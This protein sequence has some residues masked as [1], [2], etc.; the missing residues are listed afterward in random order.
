MAGGVKP[1]NI[2]YMTFTRNTILGN[3]PYPKMLFTNEGETTDGDWMQ[4]GC[5]DHI[6]YK[7]EEITPK[8][9]LAVMKGDKEKAKEL[10]GREDPRVLETTSEDTIFTYII[11]DGD[12]GKVLIGS[13]QLFVD[14]LTD[15]F[16]YAHENHR[17]KSWVWFVESC[18]SSTLFTGL[19]SDL[20]IYAMASSDEKNEPRMGCCPPHDVVAGKGL[21]TCLGSYWENIL[22]EYMEK[23]PS[24]KIGELFSYSHDEVAKG[25][26]QNVSEFGDMTMKELPISDFVGEWKVIS[27]SL[28]SMFY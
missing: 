21:Y 10:T 25:S 7:E 16:Q 13:N 26:D 5:H 27:P 19:P 23:T 24:A 4:H 6:D 17:Y 14:D 1:E 20:G 22:F 28:F 3:N 11:S 15:L 12:T 8:L 9:F 18:Y 2:I